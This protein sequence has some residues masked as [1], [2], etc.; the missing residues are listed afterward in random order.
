[1]GFLWEKITIT[2]TRKTKNLRALLDS[3]ASR[4][5]IRKTLKDGHEVDDLG[6]RAYLGKQHVL[7]PDER[8]IPSIRVIFD[9]V[10]IRDST[11]WNTEFLVMDTLIHDVILGSNFLQEMGIILDLNE[12]KIELKKRDK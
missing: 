5:Y 7:L 6:Y 9:N 11:S 8:K 10:K 12:H 2:G 1:M 3:G 4:N